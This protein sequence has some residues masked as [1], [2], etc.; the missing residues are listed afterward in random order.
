MDNLPNDRVERY[1]D[2]ARNEDVPRV[3][4]LV[5]L[6]QAGL[7]QMYR[8]DVRGFPWTLRGHPGPHGPVLRREGHELMYDA[9]VALGVACL[10]EEDQRQILG[11]ASAPEFSTALAARAAGHDHLG[12]VALAAWA[13]AE[14]AGTHAP[15]LF[16]RWEAALA[17]EERLETVYVAWALTAAVAASRHGD[18][19]DVRSSALA[20]LLREQG[21]Q[22]TFSK[23]VPMAAGPAWR[24]HVGCFADQ[25]Y[26]IQALA[27]HHND[28]PDAEALRAANACAAR[29]CELQG[30]AGQWWW[31][32]DQRTGAVVEQ[33]PV[34]SVHQHSMAPMALMEL[35]EA[36]GDDHRDEV[37]LGLSWLRTHPEVFVE[38]VDPEHHVVWR[39]VGRREPRRLSRGLKAVGTAATRGRPLPSMNLLLP[40]SSVDYECRPYEL[41]WLLYAWLSDPIHS[42]PATTRRSRDD[43]TA[44]G[45]STP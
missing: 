32:Y 11:G 1:A 23:Y 8:R 29:I 4:D 45:G 27:R 3:R 10:P 33:F 19:E 25:V 2:G 18:T 42:T 30:S 21:P 39:R 7:P 34:Y 37:S 26:P 38:L 5:S 14:V 16:S 41:G 9:I 44:A 12:A 40:P 24:R 17:G 13:A 43:V 22:G 35:W 15:A 28:R 31:H 20:A 6:A 36:G